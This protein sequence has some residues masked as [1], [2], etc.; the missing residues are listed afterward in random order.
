ML[1]GDLERRKKRRDIILSV[2]GVADNLAPADMGFR[3]SWIPHSSVE[4]SASQA[5]AAVTLAAELQ[6][7]VAVAGF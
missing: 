7:P 1:A 3:S 4:S 5:W 6:V 2:V